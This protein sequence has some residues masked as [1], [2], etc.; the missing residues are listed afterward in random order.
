MTAAGK[1]V[2]VAGATGYLG[3]FVVQAYKERGYWVRA[4]TRDTDRLAQP[5]PFMAPGI[6][7]DEVDDVYVG[8][9]TQP[10]SLEGLMDG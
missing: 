5:G 6:D 3:K 9:L 1:R 8:E 7:L 4:L 2:L 10:D